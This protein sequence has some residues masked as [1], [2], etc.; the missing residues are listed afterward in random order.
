[1]LALLQGASRQI[2]GWLQGLEAWAVVFQGFLT[3]VLIAVGG[4]FAW[5]KFFRQGE[6]DPRLQ[7]SITGT[8]KIHGGT[9]YVFATATVQNN[10]QVDVEFTDEGSALTVFTTTAEEEGWQPHRPERVFRGQ[11]LVQPGETL[12]DQKLIEIR[13][14]DEIAVRLDLAVTAGGTSTWNTTEI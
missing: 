13:H 5:Y 10:G 12:E 11:R 4:G 14:G 7:P 8:A 2:P 1:M 6:H 3:P 9:I